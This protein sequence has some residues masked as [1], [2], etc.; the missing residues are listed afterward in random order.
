MASR[1][2]DVVRSLIDTKGIL[3]EAVRVVL[4]R[5]PADMQWDLVESANGDVKK[6]AF[7]A[8]CANGHLYSINILDG[9][10]LLDGLPPGQLPREVLEH[11]LYQRAFEGW[12]FEVSR[13]SDGTMSTIKAHQ[14]HFYHFVLAGE[15]A[16][17]ITEEERVSGSRLE[18]LDAGKDQ[19]C[20]TWG[21]ELPKR[22]RELH[23]HWLSR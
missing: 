20:G 17:V 15:D 18:L 7:E 9:T 21:N 14:G 12:N 23:S 13:A 11:P 3:T 10:V 6:G 2:D 22:L 1:V 16:L 5:A 19:S 4:E 8:T